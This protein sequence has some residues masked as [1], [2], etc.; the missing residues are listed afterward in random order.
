[1]VMEIDFIFQSYQGKE[2]WEKIE[3]DTLVLGWDNLLQKQTKLSV[4]QSYNFVVTWYKSY[5]GTYEPL[6]FLAW[7]QDQKLVGLLPLAIH[8][9]ENYIVC[10][11]DELAE[12]HGFLTDVIYEE[13]FGLRCLKALK[14]DFPFSHWRLGWVAPETNTDWINESNLAKE[15]IYVQL[16]DATDPVWD[17][18]NPRKL[19][20]IKKRANV[21]RCYRQ[22]NERGDFRYERI[23][24]TEQMDFLL[25][26][27]AKQSDFKKEALFNRRLF[28]TDPH[29][30]DFLIALQAFPEISHFSVLW[31]DD[32]P[33]AFNHGY[34]DGDELCLA[35][36][37]S[38]DPSESRHSPGKLHLIELAQ[39]C[40]AEGI[41]LIDLTPGKDAYKSRF[42]NQTRDV[43]KMTFYFNARSK[44]LGDLKQQ[45]KETTFQ[46]FEKAGVKDYDVKFWKTELWAY[47]KRLRK[48]G[49]KG[50]GHML[51]NFIG[52]KHAYDIFQVRETKG[53]AVEPSLGES[54]AIKRNDFSDLIN[55]HE[56]MYYVSR[57]TLFQKSLTRFSRGDISYSLTYKGKLIHLAWVR[58]GKYELKLPGA[59]YTHQFPEDSRIIYGFCG[60]GDQVPQKVLDAF[61]EEIVKDCRESGIQDIY[62]CFGTHDEASLDYM[63][64]RQLQ[65]VFSHSHIQRFY[66]FNTSSHKDYIEKRELIPATQT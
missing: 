33:I 65:K 21:K 16:E 58:N 64:N 17:L 40:E 59:K 6:L 45:A 3:I 66:F 62:F 20:K 19:K 52:R 32:K 34:V 46:L 41:N 10:A 2:A 12:Y 39:A 23:F 30:R 48:S 7:D 37:T 26:E 42:A 53:R 63:Q 29:I 36:Y 13:A 60:F 35:G 28:E 44:Y 4:F 54:Y 27:F 24:G 9:K 18:R 22:Y 15:G 50:W 57:K 11:G 31:L 14:K 56:P 1:M 51:K 38:Y 61:Y 5:A 43:K 25:K 55:Y 47:M 8:K 49:P